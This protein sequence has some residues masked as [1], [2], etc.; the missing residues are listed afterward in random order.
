MNISSVIASSAVQST[1]YVKSASVPVVSF[2]DSTVSSS[3]SVDISGLGQILSA[4]NLFDTI[5]PAQ[6]GFSAVL[7]ATQLFVSGFN[8]FV[9]S[10]SMQSASGGSLG[11]MYAQILNAQTSGN[12]TSVLSSL[13]GI[14]V[15]YQSS[16]GQMTIDLN[17]L[18]TAY[19]ANPQGTLDLLASATTTTGQVAQKFTGFLTQ[20]DSL[21]QNAQGLSNIATLNG[22]LEA[23]SASTGASVSIAAGATASLAATG[24]SGVVGASG[25]TGTSLAVAG[26]EGV[27][28]GGAG[29]VAPVL[30]AAQNPA[31]ASAVAASAKS[32]VIAASGSPAA[33]LQNN[34]AS[35]AHVVSATVA[36]ILSASGTLAAEETA[37][38]LKAAAASV[39]KGSANLTAGAVM[40]VANTGATANALQSVYPAALAATPFVSAAQAAQAAESIA[41]TQAVAAGN[42]TAVGTVVATG[43]VA[44]LSAVE[45]QSV[46]PVSVTQ[47][48]GETVASAAVA[49]AKISETVVQ[50][51]IKPPDVLNP[52]VAA[53]VAA[54]HMID[55]MFDSA[56]PHDEGRQT[57][58]YGRSQIWPV[59]SVRQV[60]LDL[61]V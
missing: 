43:A 30:N 48:D 8:S 1:F 2:L 60:R 25:A 18:Q 55:G 26:G 20:I 28:A 16:T 53:A 21:M 32:P 15:N 29:A 47:V 54:Y 40:L 27:A 11:D 42:L 23:S 3:S 17:A 36:G 46:V 58:D 14:G 5:K 19:N 38:A 33:L 52:A 56:K 39:A 51:A 10:S 59:M 45:S 12:G 24:A 13:S 6:S 22:L 4:S 49:S 37:A 34:G 9:S 7:A 61:M 50:N 44:T 35:A 57:S 41:P 31:A